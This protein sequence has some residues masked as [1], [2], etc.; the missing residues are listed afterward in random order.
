MPSGTHI[1]VTVDFSRHGYSRYDLRIPVPQPVKPL[2][3]NL[4]QTLNLNIDMASLFAVKVPA[5]ELLLTDD[6]C[7]ADYAVTSGDILLVL[8]HS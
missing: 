5:K 8:S 3:V 4:V 1:N 2:L 6:D 7:L